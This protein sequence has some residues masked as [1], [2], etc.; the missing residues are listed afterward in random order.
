MPAQQ[1]NKTLIAGPPPLSERVVDALWGRRYEALQEIVDKHWG[2]D[3]GPSVY[4]A[5]TA[6][7]LRSI[8]LDDVRLIPPSVL[9]EYRCKSGWHDLSESDRE[10]LVEGLPSCLWSPA[11][12]VDRLV[13]WLTGDGS[14]LE[15][16]VVFSAMGKQFAS[17]WG[18]RRRPD[19]VPRSGRVTPTSLGA[20]TTDGNHDLE[21]ESQNDLEK[22]GSDESDTPERRAVI[23]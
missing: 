19:R 11:S 17:L 18:P 8:L 5:L 16:A 1:F 21:D 3:M 7:D 6:G 4:D 10:A 23:Q 12:A 9:M 13:T 2:S 14:D 20:S 15:A 22:S